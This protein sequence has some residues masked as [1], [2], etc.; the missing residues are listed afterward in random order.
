MEH[1]HEAITDPSNVA[2]AG[3]NIWMSYHYIRFCKPLQN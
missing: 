2:T 3:D 1:K